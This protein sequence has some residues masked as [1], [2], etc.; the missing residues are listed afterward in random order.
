MPLW[1]TSLSATEARYP[2]SVMHGTY[3]REAAASNPLRLTTN[4]RRLIPA[5]PNALRIAALE[6]GRWRHSHGE[7][8]SRI[9]MHRET[10][11]GPTLRPGAIRSY[12]RKCRHADA[13]DF[14]QA[15]ENPRRIG[16]FAPQT[17]GRG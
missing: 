8:R 11:S 3:L 1:R 5:L 6:T 10:Q 16:T 17:G 9:R 14:K 7:K 4:L 12:Q 2:F 13:T 15:P